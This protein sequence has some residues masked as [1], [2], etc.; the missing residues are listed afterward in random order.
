MASEITY[1]EVKFSNPATSVS[2]AAPKEKTTAPGSNPSF[3]KMLLLVFLML[4]LLLAISFFAVF[5]K[6][7][8]SCCP[9]NWK[10]FGSHCYFYSTGSKSWEK[11]KKSCSEMGAHLVVIASQEEQDFI[12]KNLE[13]NSAY[14]VGLSDLE[15][16]GHW[17]WVDQTPYNQSSTFWHEGEPSSP[18]EHC[19]IINIRSTKW[20]WN[21]VKCDGGQRSVCE[22]KQIYL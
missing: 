1:A 3:P 4:S 10:L 9:E 13:K 7:I 12:T 5:I 6:K 8:W 21:D 15:G 22:M 14:Y 17:Q 16:S 18:D 19:A 20:G 11:S 2:P